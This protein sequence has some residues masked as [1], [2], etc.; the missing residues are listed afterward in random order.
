MARLLQTIISMNDDGE[1]ATLRAMRTMLVVMMMARTTKTNDDRA[2]TPGDD[3][4]L[5]SSG[6]SRCASSTLGRL[7]CHI[8]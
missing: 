4:F 7:V 8:V 5:T 6:R 1:D 2:T 3:L